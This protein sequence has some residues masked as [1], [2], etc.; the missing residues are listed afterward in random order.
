MYFIQTVLDFKACRMFCNYGC[1]L[2][3]LLTINRIFDVFVIE[4]F[5]PT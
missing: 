3:K 1:P 4:E 2:L 5:I